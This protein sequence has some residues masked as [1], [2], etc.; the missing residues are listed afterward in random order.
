M[1]FHLEIWAI[2]ASKNS[3][4]GKRSSKIFQNCQTRVDQRAHVWRL[5]PFQGDGYDALLCLGFID[6]LQDSKW[7]TGTEKELIDGW[8]DGGWVW[9]VG[10]KNPIWVG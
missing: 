7:D 6:N 10:Y 4:I 3:F 5:E 8:M 2:W 9:I 1:P